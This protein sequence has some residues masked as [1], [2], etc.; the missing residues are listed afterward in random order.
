MEEIVLVFELTKLPSS[1]SPFANIVATEPLAYST[2]EPRFWHAPGKPIQR[3][4]KLA[5]HFDDM[6]VPC[7]LCL[8]PLLCDCALTNFVAVLGRSSLIGRPDLDVVQTI[9]DKPVNPTQG[10]MAGARWLV[11]NLSQSGSTVLDLFGGTATDS[12][13]ALKEGRNALY[14][15]FDKLQVDA[16]IERVAMFYDTE[17]SKQHVKQVYD[18][19]EAAP[20]NVQQLV[21]NFKEGR[22]ASG[23]TL[24]FTEVMAAASDPDSNLGRALS[25]VATVSRAS[26][27]EVVDIFT[28]GYLRTGLPRVAF[29]QLCQ[30]EDCYADVKA[31]WDGPLKVKFQQWMSASAENVSLPHTLPAFLNFQFHISHFPPLL[32]QVNMLNNHRTARNLMMHWVLNGEGVWALTRPLAGT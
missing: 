11:R 29:T 6:Y 26:P 23:T 25:A 1:G 22:A 12:V 9:A 30:K 18:A 4:R 14:I 24:S 3:K 21:A 2:F 13:A 27:E 5:P 10:S 8:S 28:G 19:G 20:S 7:L 17:A 32:A 31:W 15:D 16:A